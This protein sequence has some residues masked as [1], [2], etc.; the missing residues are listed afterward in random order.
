V[1][2]DVLYEIVL[3]YLKIL[4]KQTNVDLQD[5]V[6]QVSREQAIYDRVEALEK[7]LEQVRRTVDQIYE[8]RLSGRISEALFTRKYREYAGLEE[9]LQ[10]QITDRKKETGWEHFGR[11]T[12]L[13]PEDI[14]NGL[15]IRIITKEQLRLVFDRIIVFEPGEI[16]PTDIERLGLTQDSSDLLWAKGGIVFVENTAP[17]VGAMV[18]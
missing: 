12:D 8:D 7:K 6:R 3:R 4:L 13:Q 17:P 5:I 16:Q 18:P 11:L 15:S 14:I 9:E 2:E 10:Q 1:R